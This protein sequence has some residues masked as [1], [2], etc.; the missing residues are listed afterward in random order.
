[1][2]AYLGAHPNGQGA[3][4]T[5]WAPN[6]DAVSVVGDFN[7]WA[8]ERHPLQRAGGGLW[9]GFVRAARTGH[10]YKYRLQKDGGAFDKTDPF[11]FRMEPPVAGGSPGAGLAALV[12]DLAYDWGD[13]DWMARRKGPGSL[14]EPVAV[15]EVHLGSWR[16]RGHG[17]SL[18]YREIAEPL[19]DHVERLGGPRDVMF[20][21]VTLHLRG[22][23]VILDWA[24]ADFATD[25]QGLML[26]D[27]TPLFEVEDERMR[28]HPD[29]GTYVFD[30]GKPGVQSFLLSS[31]RFWLDRYHVDGLRVDAVASMLYRD[32]SRA[33]WTPNVHG[34][35]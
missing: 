26:F 15:Y 23:G 12:T 34:G 1:S 7:D 20:L 11:A 2:Y 17:E 33:E 13:D 14:G 18:S 6:A 21:V 32:Y 16:H 9:S 27:G 31:A 29:W 30:F 10:R 8:P 19:A 25:P 22:L 35:R 28:R 5:V 4:F 3:W 24:P